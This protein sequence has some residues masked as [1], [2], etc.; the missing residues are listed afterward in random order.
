MDSVMLHFALE[1]IALKI[2]LLLILR[3][4]IWWY[5]GIRRALRALEAIDASL[6]CLPAVRIRDEAKRRAA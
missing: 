2:L 5:F 3:P 1:L 4:V 6:K